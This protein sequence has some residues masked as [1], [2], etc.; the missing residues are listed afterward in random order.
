MRNHA[1]EHIERQLGEFNRIESVHLILDI[2]KYRHFAEVV[3]QAKGHIRVDAKAESDDMYVSIDSAIEKA[4]KQLRRLRDK[5]QDHKS[6]ERL[7]EVE[8][9]IQP[10]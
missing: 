7:A 9:A 4:E 5:V 2:E 10:E 8:Q 1:H 3:I 6:R